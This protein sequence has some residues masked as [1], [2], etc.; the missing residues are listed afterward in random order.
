MLM[1]LIDRMV[2]QGQMLIRCGENLPLVLAIYPRGHDSFGAALKSALR[3]RLPTL[4]DSVLGPY[5]EA[6]A[7]APSLVVADLRA[8]NS[9]ACLGHHHP[10]GSQSEVAARLAQD[11]LGSVGEIDLAIEAIR[12]WEPRPISSLA[13]AE[14]SP[15]EADLRDVRFQ[16]A[17]L[18]V[19]LHELDHLTHPTRDE[20]TVR[21]ESDAFYAA[22][23]GCTLED[24]YGVSF[25]LAAPVA[26]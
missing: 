6:L 14:S 24:R 16:T 13:A 11:T 9:C 5:R 18:T 8:Y 21:G 19:F 2:G 15:D 20:S 22:A 12:G 26:A 23:L 25:G 3:F 1:R 17:L 10:A 4:P 7:D